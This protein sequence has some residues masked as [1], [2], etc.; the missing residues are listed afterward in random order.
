MG[1]L[2]VA[3]DLG[4]GRAKWYFPDAHWNSSRS[5]WDFTIRSGFPHVVTMHNDL[6]DAYGR[7]PK[8]PIRI[9]RWIED[10]LTCS[11]VLDKLDLEYQWCWNPQ[12]R[13]WDRNYESVRHGYRMFHFEREADAVL[14]KLAHGD[15]IT[16]PR[17]DHPDGY[18]TPR[19]WEIEQNKKRIKEATGL[20]VDY[21][22]TDIPE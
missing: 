11:V 8:V 6:F 10:N 3:D 15:L 22:Q 13:S 2:I 16:T 17:V 1:Q 19:E 4:G 20:E 21:E 18:K 9:R 14:F 12:E 7:D 5:R